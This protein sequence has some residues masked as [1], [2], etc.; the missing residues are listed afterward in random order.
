[1]SEFSPAQHVRQRIAGRRRQNPNADV[2]DL[3]RELNAAKAEAYLRSIIDTAPGITDAE[4]E[5]LAAL[6]RVRPTSDAGV[7]AG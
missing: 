1:M 4:A 7:A 6:L 2:T 3:Q 5:K